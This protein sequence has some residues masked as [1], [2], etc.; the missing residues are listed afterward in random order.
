M[1]Q[2]IASGK[3]ILYG[4]DQKRTHIADCADSIIANM[5]ADT[6]NATDVSQYKGADAADAPDAPAA[7]QSGSLLDAVARTIRRGYFIH[8][9]NER[10]AYEV[11]TDVLGTVQTFY[12]AEAAKA[13]PPSPPEGGGTH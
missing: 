11:A 10:K 7:D 12:E 3:E 9:R 2:Y 8:T 5:I 6:L 4:N 13:H 1:N